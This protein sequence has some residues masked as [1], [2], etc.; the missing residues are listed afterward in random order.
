MFYKNHSC[1][2]QVKRQCQNVLTD[3]SD[4]MR[5]CYDNYII[6]I[7]HL[8][9]T[10]IVHACMGWTVSAYETIAPYSMQNPFSVQTNS[11]KSF[12]TRSSQ[13]FLPKPLTPLTSKC[14]HAEIKSSQP[15]Q[16]CSTDTSNLI[17]K[18]LRSDVS[19]SHWYWRACSNVWLIDKNN[20]ENICA[21]IYLKCP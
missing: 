2:S 5:K 13:V 15:V 4:P 19:C 7:I 16:K 11:A 12:F 21:W 9:L 8:H 17:P 1:R 14:L 10:S 3:I 20:A 18:C 6:I